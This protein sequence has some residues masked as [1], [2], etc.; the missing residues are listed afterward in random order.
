MFINILALVSP[1]YMLQVYDRVLTS[2]NSLTLLFI[3]L[4]VIFLFVVYAALEILRTQVLVRGASDL[5]Q[6]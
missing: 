4:I 1:I 5:T 2:R 3:T 6:V